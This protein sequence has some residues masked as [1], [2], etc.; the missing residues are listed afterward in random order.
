MKKLIID[1][2]KLQLELENAQRL[3]VDISKKLKSI[4]EVKFTIDY[5]ALKE[6]LQE[7][8]ISLND[9]SFADVVDEFFVTHRTLSDIYCIRHYTEKEINLEEE[10]LKEEQRVNRKKKGLISF[11]LRFVN[12]K[13]YKS[14]F[15]R[16]FIL[17]F[18]LKN[19]SDESGSDNNMVV[20]KNNLYYSLIP[21]I[22]E[23]NR[24]RILYR[25]NK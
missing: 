23:K 12:F 5:S 17:R 13:H 21:I 24:Q 11:L 1:R 6:R 8:L 3:D 19:M 4:K 9:V 22:N 18:N 7:L 15:F 16:K 10:A 14:S 2:K 25:S 20:F